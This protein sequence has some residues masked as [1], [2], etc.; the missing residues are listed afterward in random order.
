M[1]PFNSPVCPMQKSAESWIMTADYHKFNQVAT[2][3]VSVVPDTV[4]LMKQ[5]N[6][7]PGIWYAGIGLA[8]DFFSTLN[9]KDYQKPFALIAKNN[10]ITWGH[11]ADSVGRACDS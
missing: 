6:I 7:T 11:L 1:S 9:F 3:V 2:P 10:S 8:N 4:Y 5:F